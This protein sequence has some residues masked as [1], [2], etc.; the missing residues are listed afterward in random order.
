MLPV[1]FPIP[2]N[3]GSLIFLLTVP[4]RATKILSTLRVGISVAFRVTERMEDAMLLEA[5]WN[6]QKPVNSG[7]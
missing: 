5:F 1:T 2:V 6:Y 3:S 7:S 4:F